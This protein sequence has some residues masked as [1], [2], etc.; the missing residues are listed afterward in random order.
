MATTALITGI[1]GQDGSYLSELLL[2]KGYR[3]VGL[4]RRSSSGSLSRLD[5][6]RD[7]LTLVPGDL[8]DSSSL[9]SVIDEHRPDE[10][11]NLGAMS[12]VHASWSQ[13]FLTTDINATGSGVVVHGDGV[14]EFTRH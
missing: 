6:L 3:V 13:P 4:T 7:H 12:F 1:T 8:T 5:H 11:Y 9:V 2:S 14:V 10:I